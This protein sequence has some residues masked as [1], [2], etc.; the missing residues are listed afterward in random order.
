[1]DSILILCLGFCFIFTACIGPMN[2]SYKGVSYYN[3]QE[4]TTEGKIENDHM[5]E[6]KVSPTTDNAAN[7][8]ADTRVKTSD[9]L[10]SE[11][12]AKVVQ[13]NTP[14]TNNP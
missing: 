12:K 11:R 9:V 6:S 8:N 2:V 14:A 1:M 3:K 13:T 7:I 10:D 4:A 5:S